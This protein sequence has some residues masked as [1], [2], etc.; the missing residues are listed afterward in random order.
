MHT[1]P[2][3]TFEAPLPLVTPAR[4]AR[5]PAAAG[6]PTRYPLLATRYFFSLPL[7]FSILC[8]LSPALSVSAETLT[9]TTYNINNYLPSSRAV[10]GT[11]YKSYM[12]PEAEKKALRTII[13]TLNADIIAIQEIGPR[14]FLEELR[15]DLKHDGVDYPHAEILESPVT[16]PDRHIAVLSRRPFTAVRK[17]TDLTFK[18]YDTTETVKRGLLEVRVA[19]DAGELTLFIVHLKSRLTERDRPDDYESAKRRAGEAE[20]VR[21]RVLKHFPDPSAPGALFLILGDFNDTRANRPLRALSQR[22]KT[23]IS[24]PLPGGDSHGEVWTYFYSRQDTYSRVDHVLVSP[25]LKKFVQNSTVTIYDGP[26]VLSASDHRPVTVRLNL[27]K[28]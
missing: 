21:D 18:Y 20:A 27:G 16:D 3:S 4:K 26:D 25:A 11:Y 28:K 19:T 7:L 24:T 15:R 22:G 8:L 1:H 14:P 6:G 5:R 9:I 10:D 23:Q 13:K 17:H 2:H 12:K